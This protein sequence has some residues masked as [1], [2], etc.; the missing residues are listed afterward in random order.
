MP[1]LA[2]MSLSP[3]PSATP[4]SSIKEEKE[5]SPILPLEAPALEPELRVTPQT[6]PDPPNR[7]INSEAD[8]DIY[9]LNNEG[10]ARVAKAG[11]IKEMLKLGEGISGS[12]SK[13]QLRK[14]GQV[15][16]I[17]VLPIPISDL[18]SIDYH[19]GSYISRTFTS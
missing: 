4:S 7:L 12:V 9:E 2:A 16:A 19:D 3:S 15:F 6:T 5:I 11:G 8:D 18:T 1:Q 10:W 17:K 13:C 14:S